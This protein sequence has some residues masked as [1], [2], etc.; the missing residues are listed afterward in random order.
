MK[1]YVRNYLFA[2]PSF[3]EGMS[4]AHDLGAM[5]Q[6]YNY[7]DSVQGADFKALANDWRAVGDD[8]S[9]VMKKYDRIVKIAS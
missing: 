2:E 1:R 7:S 8:I 3:I 5:L 9:S 4:R 6:V